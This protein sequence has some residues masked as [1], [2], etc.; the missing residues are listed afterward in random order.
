M[1]A[2]PQEAR[3]VTASPGTPARHRGTGQRHCPVLALS[4][5]AFST[6]A[7]TGRSA[8]WKTVEE[9]GGDGRGGPGPGHPRSRVRRPRAPAPMAPKLSEAQRGPARRPGPAAARRGRR[10]PG[11]SST[12]GRRAPGRAS[13]ARP[14]A[15]QRSRHIRSSVPA[16][17]AL[18]SMT[19]EC[20]PGRCGL[21]GSSDLLAVGMPGHA[22]VAVLGGKQVPAPL[23]ALGATLRR[24][25]QGSEGRSLRVSV[26]LRPLRCSL[27]GSRPATQ[28]RAPTLSHPRTPPSAYPHRLGAGL[29]STDRASSRLP[30]QP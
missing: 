11:P 18:T 26:S 22:G 6:G 25:H 20:Q 16:A 30:H 28:R 4:R 8:A 15:A 17:G 7:T 10:L 13:A 1:G 2:G 12:R 9:D 24:E 29:A 5:T 19:S 14:A 27:C 3:A 23:A 21:L